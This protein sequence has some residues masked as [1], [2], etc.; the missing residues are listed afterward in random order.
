MDDD[1]RIEASLLSSAM[2]G[3]A[4]TDTCTVTCYWGSQGRSGRDEGGRIK[5]RP[6]GTGGEGEGVLSYKERYRSTVVEVER[7]HRVK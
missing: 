3:S 4:S 2:S 1:R 5:E 6:K 7:Y